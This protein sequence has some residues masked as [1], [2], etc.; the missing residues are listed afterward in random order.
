MIHAILINPQDPLR[1]ITQ[2]PGRRLFY[3][4]EGDEVVPVPMLVCIFIISHEDKPLAQMERRP[5]L[6]NAR[7]FMGQAKNV[8]E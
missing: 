5:R 3:N 1:A 4:A 6:I 8:L 7:I 2:E